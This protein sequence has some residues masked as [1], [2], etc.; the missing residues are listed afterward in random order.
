LWLRTLTHGAILGGGAPAGVRTRTTW[1][2]S[3]VQGGPVCHFQHRGTNSSFKS[4]HPLGTPLWECSVQASHELLP[5]VGRLHQGDD[6][7]QMLFQAGRTNFVGQALEQF[8]FQAS[9][10]VAWR[11]PVEFF[12]HARSEAFVNHVI[13]DLPRT[14]GPL[15]LVFVERG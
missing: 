9:L 4:E 7:R 6:R 12:L 3:R 10:A 5:V 15:I 13:R 14:D 8:L 2:V 1:M 11:Q